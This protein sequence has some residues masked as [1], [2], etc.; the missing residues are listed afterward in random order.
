[1]LRPCL[2]GSPKHPPCRAHWRSPAPAADYGGLPLEQ[3]VGLLAALCQL[4]MDSPSLR[5]TLERRLEEQQRIKKQAGAGRR[6]SGCCFAAR[7]GAR[8]RVHLVCAHQI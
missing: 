8:L 4:A 2:R 7:A 3:R 1:M 5:D 6:T